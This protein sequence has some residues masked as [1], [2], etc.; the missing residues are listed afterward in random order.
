MRPYKNLTKTLQITLF[1]TFFT[2]LTLFKST[3]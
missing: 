1:F 2:F 3:V